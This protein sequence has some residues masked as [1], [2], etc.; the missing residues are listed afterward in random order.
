[1]KQESTKGFGALDIGR[2]PGSCSAYAITVLGFRL[3]KHPHSN[4]FGRPQ[5]YFAKKFLGGHDDHFVK[6]LE[7]C[8]DLAVESGKRIEIA[9]DF[10]GR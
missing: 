8:F 6:A 10:E 9:F 2:P 3:H 1:M 5:Q 7:V 4:V